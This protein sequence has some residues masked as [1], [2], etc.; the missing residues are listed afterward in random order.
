MDGVLVH[1]FN[2]CKHDWLGDD[3]MKY[4]LAINR[5]DREFVANGKIKILAGRNNDRRVGN[6]NV[7]VK[8]KS[9]RIST[10]ER[11]GDRDRNTI[12]IRDPDDSVDRRARRNSI[13]INTV[14]QLILCFDRTHEVDEGRFARIVDDNH[15]IGKDAD[16]FYKE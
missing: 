14:I 10:K 3:Q 13:E 9:A 11:I 4:L 16:I 5:V 8:R 15:A 1:T 12:R 7:R 2:A 6:N